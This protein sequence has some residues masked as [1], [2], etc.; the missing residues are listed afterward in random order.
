M[1]AFHFDGEGAA[2]EQIKLDRDQES[3]KILR[4]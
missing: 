1:S 4:R 2:H 3:P